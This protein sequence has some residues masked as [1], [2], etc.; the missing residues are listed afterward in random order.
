MMSAGRPVRLPWLMSS[1]CAGMFAFGIVMAV[2]GA[3]LPALFS[4]IAFDKGE[5]GVLFLVMNLAMLGMSVLFGPFVDRF[6][7]RVFLAG[8]A[9][10]VAASLFLFA[11]AASYAVLVAAA[12][13]LGFGGG[14]LNGGTNALAADLYPERRTSALSLLGIFFGFGALAVP[15][16]IGTLLER[17]GLGTILAVAA[18]LALAPGALYAALKFPGAKQAQGFPIARAAEVVRHPTLW[19]LGVLLFFQSGNEFTVGG[20]LSTHLHESFGLAASTAALVLAGYW[21]AIMA[22][23]LVTARLAG[24][25]ADRTIIFASAGLSLAAALLL[26]LA[27]S[28][29]AAAAGAV[30]LG[31]GFAAIYPTTLAVAGGLFPNLTGTAFSLI[32]VVALV[33]GMLCP[34]LAGRIAQSEGVRAA[35]FIPVANCAMIIVI[36]AALARKAGRVKRAPA[37]I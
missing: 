16:L 27:P 35:L 17:L 23:R 10:L 12:A 26:A 37:G 24:R 11:R 18:V 6:G 14:G 9:F 32:F 4:R 29:G 15:F 20:W 28:A 7:F 19:L 1:A 34:W 13:V 25:V 36:Q 21:A 31:F 3:S 8:S 22:G 2:L 5:A 30:A 33:G